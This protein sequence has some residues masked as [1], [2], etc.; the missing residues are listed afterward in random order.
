VLHSRGPAPVDVTGYC[1]RRREVRQLGSRLLRR[2][3]QQPSRS[4]RGRKGAPLPQLSRPGQYRAWHP[5]RDLQ[6]GVLAGSL[7]PGP[8][9]GVPRLLVMASFSPRCEIRQLAVFVYP[10]GI[11]APTAE[12]ITVFCGRRGKPVKKPRFIPAERAHFW[13]RKLQARRLGTVAVL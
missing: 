12:R 11:K 2:Q 5:C 7:Q 6:A 9:A 13:A 1:Q 10:G 8:D 3:S 4:A